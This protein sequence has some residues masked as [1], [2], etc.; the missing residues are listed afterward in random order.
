[1]TAGFVSFL[2]PLAASLFCKKK[3]QKQRN[4]PESHAF[5]PCIIRLANS[6]QTFS[7]FLCVVGETS[8]ARFLLG[9]SFLPLT[10]ALGVK[11]YVA[12]KK[13]TRSQVVYHIM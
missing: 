6:S 10:A 5:C 8:E 2:F 11:K 3:K 4:L 7:S 13:Y 1:M 9:S 12:L